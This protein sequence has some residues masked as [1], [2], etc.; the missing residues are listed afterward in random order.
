MCGPWWAD[1]REVLALARVSGGCAV[2]VCLGS[3]MDINVCVPC[4]VHL[5]QRALWFMAYVCASVFH[6][7]CACVSLLV[8]L[9][10]VCGCS[11]VCA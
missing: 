6:G 8:W 4:L 3:A 10:F 9:F 5:S 11:C 7:L 2:V 1:M